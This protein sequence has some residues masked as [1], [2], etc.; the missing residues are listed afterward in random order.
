MTLEH[1][2]AVLFS[3]ADVEPRKGRLGPPLK[4]ARNEYL[5]KR[6]ARQERHRRTM[7]GLDNPVDGSSMRQVISAIRCVMTKMRALLQGDL[8]SG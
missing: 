8:A 4:R 6:A 7:S 1:A 3:G 5:Q 2:V